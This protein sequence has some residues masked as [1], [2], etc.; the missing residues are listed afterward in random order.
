M[1]AAAAWI[2]RRD[3]DG[4]ALFVASDHH[5]PDHE[6]FRRAAHQEPGPALAPWRAAYTIA[7]GSSDAAAAIL[8]YEFMR[9]TG[10]PAT[11]LP[12]S[13]FS[14]GEGVNDEEVNAALAAFV[15]AQLD[16]AAGHA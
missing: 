1:A 6:A 2:A 15:A 3:P 12:P 13:V 16:G 7:R 4:V 5:I 14:L 11:S 10:R 8:A 9:E